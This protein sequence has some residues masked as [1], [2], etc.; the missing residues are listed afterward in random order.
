MDHA[1]AN[2]RDVH[3]FTTE[4]AVTE[5]TSLCDGNEDKENFVAAL[6]NQAAM[7]GFMRGLRMGQDSARG[8]LPQADVVKMMQAANML[9]LK[10][11]IAWSNRL[12]LFEDK[13][14]KDGLA[15]SNK[16]NE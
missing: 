6:I 7:G 3:E 15:S 1:E 11:T 14:Y 5:R 12:W 9:I 8:P 2:I 4:W 10:Q 13:E 16:E